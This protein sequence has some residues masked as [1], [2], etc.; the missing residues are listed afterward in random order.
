MNKQKIKNLIIKI[1]SRI[2]N[3]NEKILSE[4]SLFSFGIVP[5]SNECKR[6]INAIYLVFNINISYA[7][8]IKL[9]FVSDVV[10]I[11]YSKQEIKDEI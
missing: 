5:F 2:Y 4:Y 11:I 8:F 3:E 10:E 1:I 9:M 6:L 7:E